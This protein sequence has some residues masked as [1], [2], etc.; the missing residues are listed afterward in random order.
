LAFWAT[1]IN[2]AFSFLG[3]FIIFHPLLSR[4]N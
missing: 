3:S 4:Q 1:F 2:A